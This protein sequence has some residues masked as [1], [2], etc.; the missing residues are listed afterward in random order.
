MRRRRECLSC[1]ERFTTF[2]TAEL[3]LPHVVKSDASRQPFDQAKLRAGIE[4]ALEKRPVEVLRS[5]GE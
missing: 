1:A 3:V 2:E 5:V 4:R